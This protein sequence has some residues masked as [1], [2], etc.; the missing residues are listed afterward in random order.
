MGTNLYNDVDNNPTTLIDP[1]GLDV[2]PNPGTTGI[3]L[4]G[5]HWY[6]DWG[7]PGFTSGATQAEWSNFPN[8]RSNPN[9]HPPVDPVDECFYRHDVCLLNSADSK[10]PDKGRAC[11][12]KD[13]DKKTTE[14]LARVRK[15]YRTPLPW[16]G[17]IPK[18]WDTR[19]LEAEFNRPDSLNSNMGEKVDHFIHY[20]YLRFYQ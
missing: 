8:N 6:G 10:I 16:G 17:S 3:P 20:S 11:A 18:Y 2:L 15:T 19:P 9:F 13:R 1:F 5:N 4:G 12:R 7:G 14:C